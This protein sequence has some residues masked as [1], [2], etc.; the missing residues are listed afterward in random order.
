MGKFKV[1][2]SDPI[3][4]KSLHLT[5]FKDEFC[6]A[7]TKRFL[8]RGGP[9][10]LAIK[11]VDFDERNAKHGLLRDALLTLATTFFG[12][13]HKD[14]ST[15]QK[16]Y[17]LYGS[18]LKSLNQALCTEEAKSDDVLLCV[19][20]LGLLE[21]F[22]PSSRSS[23]LMHIG[24]MEQ[25]LELRGP[26]AHRDPFSRQ[27]LQGIRRMLIFGSLST[28]I[29]S[30]LA[31]REWK[32]LEWR[33][34]A[35]QKNTDEDLLNFLA[36]CPALFNRRDELLHLFESDQTARA[37][38]QRKSILEEG[39]ALLEELRIW[40]QGWDEDLRDASNEGRNTPSEFLSNASS[41]DESLPETFTLK[42]SE[43]AATTMMLYFSIHIHILDLITSITTIPPTA[44]TV[45][46]QESLDPQVFP[47]DLGPAAQRHFDM[48]AEQKHY[49][50]RLQNAA[51]NICRLVPYHL[52]IRSKLDAGSLHIGGMAIKL[53]W[54]AFQGEAT[55]Q[56]RW[57]KETILDFQNDIS[58]A[59][60]LWENDENARKVP[61]YK[62]K[63][64]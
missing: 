15:R 39:K 34:D 14:N 47:L 46:R 5:A 37:L 8:L 53:A 59:K 32:A 49:V 36:D 62:G 26:E 33:S 25:L 57:L 54:R 51:L 20:T 27:I 30:I 16:G 28:S 23:W 17:R 64:S 61:D 50:K 56:G 10:H 52:S 42:G 9:V 19:V 11:I 18:T 41:G 13:Q 7:Y 40:R 22:V 24:G 31:K 3:V 55:A 12:N 60:G 58:F 1:I 35:I 2:E 45:V 43:A 4:P 21:T 63:K 48:I 44:L 29:P 38:E 6:I